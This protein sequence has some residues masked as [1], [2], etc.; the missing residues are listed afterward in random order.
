[1]GL[2]A[3]KLRLQG[4]GHLLRNINVWVPEGFVCI[5]FRDRLHLT[6]TRIHLFR[7]PVNVRKDLS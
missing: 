4:C 3:E 5:A 6:P 7:L 1:M 2:W